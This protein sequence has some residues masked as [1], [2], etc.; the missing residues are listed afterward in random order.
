MAF[1]IASCYKY[2]GL[3]DQAP[4]SDVRVIADAEWSLVKIDSCIYEAISVYFDHLL[5]LL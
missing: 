1:L 3:A 4:N 2:T 5:Y